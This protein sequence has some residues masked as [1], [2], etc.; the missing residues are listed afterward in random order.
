MK[1]MQYVDMQSWMGGE[2]L[3]KGDKMRMGN[4]LELGVGLLDK[5]V[6]DV[7]SKIADEVKRKK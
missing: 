3:L 2:I 6:L 4:C 7:G 5:V 1:K